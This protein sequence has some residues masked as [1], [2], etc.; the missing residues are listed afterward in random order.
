MPD[1]KTETCPVCGVVIE[2]DAKVLFSF[3][4]AGTRARLWARVCNYAQNPAC[5]NQ[6]PD[7]IGDVVSTDY[8]N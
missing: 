4:P 3:G 5:I 6:N 2:N 1:V 8:Y 7:K